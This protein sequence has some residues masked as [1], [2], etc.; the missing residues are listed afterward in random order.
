MGSNSTLIVAVALCPSTVAEIVVVPGATAVATPSVEMAAIVGSALLHVT[1]RPVSTCPSASFAVAMNACVPPS[2]TVADAGLT[3]SE[4]TGPC[5]VMLAAAER[6]STVAVTFV[7]PGPTPVTRPV[8]ETVATARLADDQITARPV[9]A[10]PAESRA[11]AVSCCV[12][13]MASVV[14]CGATSTLLTVIGRTTA[15][16][17]VADRPW[18]VAV[19]VAVPTARAVTTPVALIEATVGFPELHVTVGA[20]IPA[21]ASIVAVSGWLLPIGS[22]RTAGWRAIARTPST[23]SVTLPRAAPAVA[24]T[25]ADP[26]LRAV[27]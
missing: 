21:S 18:L 14:V 9:S 27:T 1:G 3:A 10:F 20:V 23:V 7:V 19:I 2:V 12:P 13:P 15:T 22:A 25:M 8:A 24:V 6:P 11:A 4:A 16:V 17:A 26:R 5:T